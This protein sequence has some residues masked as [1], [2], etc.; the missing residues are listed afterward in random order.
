MDKSPHHQ[1]DEEAADIFYLFVTTAR[2]LKFEFEKR[3]AALNLPIPISGP[4]LRLLMEV[5]KAEQIRMNELA[6]TLDLKPR[7]ITDFIKALEQSG[8]IQR[9]VDPTDRR[10]AIIS[11]TD[12]A[13]P[14]IRTIR[15]VSAEISEKLMEKLSSEQRRQMKDM[16][17]TLV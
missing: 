17:L 13:K 5:W 7:T 16:L 1:P 10:A 6:A 8:L 11:L 9:T 14:H 12:M 3:L 15:S 4:R 2:I